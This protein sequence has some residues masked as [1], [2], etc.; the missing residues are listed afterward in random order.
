MQPV[1]STRSTAQ[2][3]PKAAAS[4]AAAAEK[5][6]RPMAAD[7]LALSA[8][9]EKAAEAPEAPKSTLGRTI[10]KV[11]GALGGGALGAIPGGVMLLAAYMAPIPG[12]PVAG[13]IVGGI[14]AALGGWGGLKLGGKLG[15][16]IQNLFKRD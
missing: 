8:K 16:K 14:G 12:S 10:G 15:E 6:A 4:T 3:T 5:T 2:V 11:A 1:N 13:L 7:A 9:A